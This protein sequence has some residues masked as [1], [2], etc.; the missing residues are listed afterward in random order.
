MAADDFT[1]MAPLSR[2]LFD[3]YLDRLEPA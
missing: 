1:D 2:R 3:F